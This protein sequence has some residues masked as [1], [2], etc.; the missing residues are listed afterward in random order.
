MTESL[1]DKN[2]NID[3]C[4]RDDTREDKE[5]RAYEATP[6]DI[7]DV[8]IDSGI[9]KKS[10][11]LVDMGSGKGRVAIYLSNQI[12]CHVTGVEYDE[13]MYAKSLDNLRQTSM[14]SSAEFINVSA[15]NYEVQDRDT[16]VFFFNPFSE[17]ILETVIANI[18][19]SYYKK[20]RDIKL[21]FYYPSLEYV[22]R[23][24]THD[25][26]EFLD[27]IDC[28]HLYKDSKGREC[29]MIFRVI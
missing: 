8:I 3:T 23:L 4:G 10:D 17:K 12:G 22:G 7:L 25:S 27:E 19:K 2:F 13:R 1:I 11:C 21:L 9:I 16:A 20:E 15:E 28:S 5:H 14:E 26:L 18:V 29:I 24:M 6:Y